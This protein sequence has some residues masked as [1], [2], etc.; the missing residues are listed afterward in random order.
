MME[1]Q[2]KMAAFASSFGSTGEA[3]EEIYHGGMPE[4]EAIDDQDI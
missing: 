4:S 1:P 2:A 3:V